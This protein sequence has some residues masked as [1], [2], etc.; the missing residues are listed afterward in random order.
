[1]TSIFD[2]IKKIKIVFFVLLMASTLYAQSNVKLAFAQKKENLNTA[3]I[4]V[5]I[6]NNSNE[7]LKVLTWNTPFER[8]INADIFNIYNGQN[9]VQ[10]MGRLVKR[11]QPT[12]ADYVTLQAREKR[13]IDVDLSKYYQMQKQGDY[14]VSYKGEIK[15]LTPKGNINVL[16]KAS[17]PSMHIFFTPPLTQKKTFNKTLSA[18]KLTPAF[19]SCSQTQIDAL[20]AAHDAAI[21][22]AQESANTMNA[23]PN[24]TAGDRYYTWFGIPDSGRQNTVK[25]HFENI[26][27]TLDTKNITFNCGECSTELPNKYNTTY[28][29]VYP[30]QTY[31]IYLCG[32]FWNTTTSGTDS[33]AG[34]LVHETSHF[35]IVAGTSDYAYG[36]T[37]CKTLAVNNPNNA[38]FNADSHEYFA[39]NMPSLSMVDKF[40]T[41]T[42]LADVIQD[43]PITS[44]INVS[45]EKDMYT[46]TAQNT[47]IYTFYTSGSLDAYGALYNATYTSVK[48]DDDSGVSRN[49]RLSYS[50]TAGQTYY[51]EVREYSTYTGAYT[52]NS[53]FDID[54]DNDGIGNATDTD[55]D[56]DGV[57]DVNDTFPLDASESIDTDN[58]GIGN[59]A[60][61]DDDNDGILD[62]VEIANGLDP[63]NASDAQSDLD[64]D[65]FSNSMEISLGTDIHNANSTPLWVPIFTGNGLLII[66]PVAP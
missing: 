46:F 34:T 21:S 12:D 36:K 42:T 50:M 66:V 54:T 2:F 16:S 19:T 1:M 27:S 11:S 5:T 24:N 44:D 55:D 18:A 59:N 38:V 6:M 65:G 35:S 22:L 58:D 52:L 23:A 26:Y 7:T 3:L 57:V 64:G 13:T 39:E 33:Q 31:T 60:D 37:D 47:G 29:Y 40:A 63:L 9:S 30:T 8:T 61:T 48:E 53:S 45:G 56:N 10:Y 43:L 41:A 14:L 51:L 49:F 4:S 20:N 17:I 28:A 62:T 25:T 32:A 15:A